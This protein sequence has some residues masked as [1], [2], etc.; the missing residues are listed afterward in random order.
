[1]LIDDE[2]VFMDKKAVTAT[3]ASKVIDCG[4]GGDAV[5]N[6]L[7][8]RVICN[9]AATAAGDATLTLAL[10]TSDTVSG[11]GDSTALASPKTLMLT[12]AI[13]KA[14]IVKGATLLEVRLPKGLKRYLDVNFTVGTGP[15]TA[16]K[17]T[18]FLS[19]EK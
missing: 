13:A 4:S 15:L 17:F 7:F 2:L 6:E 19:T 10:R 3:A 12:G 9:E 8:L 1:M 18:A 5:N 14:D 11:T 16:G